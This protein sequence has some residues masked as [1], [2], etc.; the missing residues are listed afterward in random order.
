MTE[1]G[2]HRDLM[3]ALIAMLTMWYARAPKVSVSGNLLLYY[4][5]GNNHPHVSP[6]VFVV[7]G[8]SRRNRSYYLLWEQGKSQEENERLRRENESLRRRLANAV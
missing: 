4:I 2:G 1:A 3:V 6:D 7:R 8:V 5:P